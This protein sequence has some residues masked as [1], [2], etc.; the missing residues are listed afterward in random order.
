MRAFGMRFD[1]VT[2]ASARNIAQSQ[3]GA[4]TVEYGVVVGGLAV[5]IAAALVAL[6]V[7]LGSLF[8]GTAQMTGDIA[9]GRRVHETASPR[10]LRLALRQSFE[11]TREG[12]SGPAPRRTLDQIGT[13]LSLARE[14]SGGNGRETVSRS[15]DIPAGT[16]RAAISFDMSFVDSWDSESALVYVNGRQVAEGRFSWTRDAPPTLTRTPV[17]GITVTALPVSRVRAG[18]WSDPARGTDH[19]YTVTIAVADPGETLTLGF[20]TTLDQDQSDESLLIGNVELRVG[21]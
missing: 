15:F 1:R 21:E 14:S 10:P 8:G 12:W 18:S 11:T 7:G 5:G 17:S 4:T 16:A 19:T 3:R 13:G 9:A 20:G 2:C 6:G